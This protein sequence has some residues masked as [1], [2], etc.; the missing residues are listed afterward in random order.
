MTPEQ[1]TPKMHWE[2]DELL[3]TV[4]IL[5]NTLAGQ[6]TFLET[7]EKELARRK[8]EA[9]IKMR[10]INQ[11]MHDLI[12]KEERQRSAEND[13]LRAQN[14]ALKV[15]LSSVKTDF[16]ARLTGLENSIQE[17]LDKFNISMK[18]S[19]ND[20][21][22]NVTG[23]REDLGKVRSKVDGALNGLVQIQSEMHSNNIRVESLH[24]DIEGLYDLLGVSRNDVTEA[25]NAGPVRQRELLQATPV[26]K[27]I[28]INMRDQNDSLHGLRKE[29]MAHALDLEQ[30]KSQNRATMDTIQESSEAI[31]KVHEQSTQ[32]D[33]GLTERIDALSKA[34]PGASSSD[35]RN[36]E[37]YVNAIDTTINTLQA[38]MRNIMNS[39]SGKADSR[40][41]GQKADTEFVQ[42][43]L[44]HL[45]ERIDSLGSLLDA[46][47]SKL[48][49]DMEAA[50]KRTAASRAPEKTPVATTTVVVD[51]GIDLQAM[52]GRLRRLDED[53]LALDRDKIGRQ[54]ME[55]CLASALE[56]LGN[57]QPQGPSAATDDNNATSLRFRCLSCNRNAGPLVENV[58]DR[59]SAPPFPPS[60]LHLRGESAR[61]HQSP[62]ASMP[63]GRDK[64]HTEPGPISSRRKLLNY[65]DWLKAREDD[66]NDRLEKNVKG[67]SVGGTASQELVLLEIKSPRR[68]STPEPHAVGTDGRFYTGVQQQRTTD[69]PQMA[70][71]PLTASAL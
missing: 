41:V 65:Y 49:N 68:M 53:V 30:I 29:I 39:L 62:P 43:S 26:F 15:E 27:P 38:E 32:R 46:S 2:M 63:S 4:S 52:Q 8:T 35:N 66:K 23:V 64:G 20:V 48:E 55:E 28:M 16:G 33:I 19:L 6:Q 17:R 56:S 61:R 71:R 44:Q 18:M 1:L 36:I 3:R 9:E 34:S 47:R 14:A 12:A 11:E 5:W 13:H 22:T 59:M 42:D 67:A 70:E 25:N 37:S 51:N 50:M 40:A 21:N 7:V 60:T 24:V 10:N 58:R 69:R 54:E 31:R 57:L 45:Q